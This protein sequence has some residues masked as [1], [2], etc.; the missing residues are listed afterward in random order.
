MEHKVMVW[1]EPYMVSVHS[2]SKSV[3]V[4]SGEY[5]GKF[6]EVE[7]RSEGAAIIRWREAATYRG[8]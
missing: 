7:G 6:I 3:W 8:N 5:L 2:K 1:D 4:A